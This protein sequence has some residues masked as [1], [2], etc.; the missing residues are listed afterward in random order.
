MENTD[1][2]TT[3]LEFLKLNN[4]VITFGIVFHVKEGR[5]HR[6]WCGTEEKLMFRISL[7]EANNG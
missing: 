6:L 7:K 2:Y 1:K 4:P 3:L 5:K